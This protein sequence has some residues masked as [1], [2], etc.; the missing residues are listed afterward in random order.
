MVTDNI[1]PKVSIIAGIVLI[2]VGASFYLFPW[3]IPVFY[4]MPKGTT[5]PYYGI[6]V[7]IEMTH[8]IRQMKEKNEDSQGDEP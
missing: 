8:F 2:L 3:L 5:L 1:D 4:D 6:L 7:A